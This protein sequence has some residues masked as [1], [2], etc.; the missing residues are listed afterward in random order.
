MRIEQLQYLA[1]AVEL[2]SLRR[3]SD[4]LHVSQAAMSEAITKLERELGAE[5]LERH[6]SGVRATEAGRALLP[7]VLDALEALDRVRSANSDDST[8]RHLIRVGTVNA[9]TASLL[10][11]ATRAITSQNPLAS[12]DIRS[13][14]QHEI[15]TGLNDGALD[16][17]LVNLLSGDDLPPDLGALQLKQGAPVAVVSTNH[18]LASSDAINIETLRSEAFIG[19]RK[20]YI[21]HRLAHRLFGA[22][23]PATWHTTDGAEM[24]KLMVA[25]GLGV[26]LLPDYSIDGDP[27]VRAGLITSRP[28]VEVDVAVSVVALYRRQTRMRPTVRILLGEL[29]RVAA[30]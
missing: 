12:V 19:M 26:S 3:A 27:L 21:M 2:G 6:R 28:I 17:G 20:G 1:T 11:P 23:L 13:L 14:Q 9:G 5:L 8:A 29:Q 22:A 16:L 25:D 7:H 10:L 24:A 18:P 15:V 30:A 4:R